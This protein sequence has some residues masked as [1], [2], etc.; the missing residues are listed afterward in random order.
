M[1]KH[2][3]SAHSSIY[4]MS[5]MKCYEEHKPM[6]L[7][8]DKFILGGCC[9][10]HNHL[11]ADVYV[12]LDD[13]MLGETS[14]YPWTDKEAVL[15]PIPDMKTPTD[16][17]QFDN[18]ID[19]IQDKVEEGKTVHVGC[20]GGHGRT[21][22]VLSALVFKMMGIEDAISYVRENYCEE[23][24]ETL[25]QTQ[26][27][28]DHYGIKKVKL[29]SY[30][31]PS[32]S[33][34]AGKVIPYLSDDFA[35]EDADILAMEDFE[36]V[37]DIFTYNEE[38]SLNI[39]DILDSEFVENEITKEVFDSIQEGITLEGLGKIFSLIPDE[40]IFGIVDKTLFGENGNKI[41]FHLTLYFM[42][43]Y[44]DEAYI[45]L[46]SS[47]EFATITNEEPKTAIKK[48]IL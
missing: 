40:E 35:P 28:N 18:L 17:E 37:G 15:F 27:L 2:S 48:Q 46:D 4:S 3:A 20:L 31:N 5:F 13:I 7:G 41:G 8:G 19:W 43:I 12:G 26:W 25:G 34:F 1:K 24:V 6:P 22:M 9:V 21:G 47:E 38:S 23:A 14:L 32:K 33:S 11:E 42:E 39:F 45:L 30:S 44:V 29:P 16:F 36:E 10:D